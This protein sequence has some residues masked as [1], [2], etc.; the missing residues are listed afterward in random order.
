MLFFS[1][2]SCNKQ[3]CNGDVKP[4]THY[5]DNDNNNDDDDDDDNDDDNN[6]NNDNNDASF[7]PKQNKTKQR[8]NILY[9]DNVMVLC[10]LIHAFLVICVFC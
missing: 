6:N 9:I 4:L 7:P 1:V 3:T 2:D 10:G 8:W 5:N